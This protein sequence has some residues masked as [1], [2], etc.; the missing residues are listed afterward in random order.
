MSLILNPGLKID[1]TKLS[2]QINWKEKQWIRKNS[3]SIIQTTAI[4]SGML[5]KKYPSKGYEGGCLTL[6]RY[7]LPIATLLPCPV[8]E[9]EQRV[10]VILFMENMHLCGSADDIYGMLD[11]AIPGGLARLREQALVDY[12]ET[13]LD[14]LAHPNDFIIWRKGTR[15]PFTKGPVCPTTYLSHSGSKIQAKYYLKSAHMA[16]KGHPQ[17]S[18]LLRIEMGV[19]GPF[20]FSELTALENPFRDMLVFD[21]DLFV[22]IVAGH[23]AFGAFLYDYKTEGFGTAYRKLAA[24]RKT[25]LQALVA[26]SIPSWAIPSSIWEQWPYTL[27]KYHVLKKA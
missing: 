16:K 1:K 24:K 17:P 5:L 14:V 22:S 8:F 11:K 3:L 15:K 18:P 7:G 20:P 19:K 25:K 21:K 9:D 2:I 27:E 12:I 13:P 23:S 26:P 6:Q 10:R 4:Q